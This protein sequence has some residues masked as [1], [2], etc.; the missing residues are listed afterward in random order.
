MNAKYAELLKTLAKKVN[1][2]I[3]SKSDIEKVI[4]KMKGKKNE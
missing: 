1:D 4:E 3:V 2:N